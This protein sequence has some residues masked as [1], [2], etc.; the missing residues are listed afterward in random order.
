MRY[1]RVN[2]G[3]LIRSRVEEVG[4]SYAQFAKDIGRQRQNIEKSVFQ[5]RSLD[6]ELLIVISEILDYDFFSYY[7][8]E[9]GCNKNDYDRKVDSDVKATLTIEL[10]KEKKEQVLKLVFG[11]NNLEI[12]TK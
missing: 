11:D 10:K 4:I 3:E 2:I 12:L 1:N 9:D 7:R 5:K 8:N 6:T